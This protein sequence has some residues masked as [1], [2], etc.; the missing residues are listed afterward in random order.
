MLHYVKA[1][2]RAARFCFPSCGPWH[3]IA[4]LCLCPIGARH[5]ECSVL[6]APQAPREALR[7]GGGYFRRR[8][9]LTTQSSRMGLL[10]NIALWASVGQPR[11]AP[12]TD[13]MSSVG[14]SVARHLHRLSQ[15]A[16]SACG[17]QSHNVAHHNRGPASERSPAKLGD[18]AASIQVL[19]T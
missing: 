6:P 15:L 18:D 4:R 7:V 11:N 2:K 19:R 10:H 17:R 5:A 3:I 13:V 14:H 8:P 12:I 9:H 1:R 16:P